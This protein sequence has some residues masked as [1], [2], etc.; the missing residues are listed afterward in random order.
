MGLP[1]I[2]LDVAALGSCPR[3]DQLQERPPKC[4]LGVTECQLVG[5]SSLRM[6]TIC[7]FVSS[8]HNQ[9]FPR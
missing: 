5:R 4:T 2:G 6:E 7:T 8:R 1:L 3:Q 9:S